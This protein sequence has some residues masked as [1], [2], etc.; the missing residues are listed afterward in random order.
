MPLAIDF[1]TCNTIIARWNEALADVEAPS[2]PGLSGRYTY[3]VPRDGE[4]QTANVIPSLIHYGEEDNLRVGAQVSDAGLVNHR[5]T[6]RWLKMDM[7]RGSRQKRRVNGRLITR[8]DAAGELLGRMLLFT[9]GHLGNADDDLVATIPVEAY[10]HYVEWLREA[11]GKHFPQGVLVVDEAT[12]C[13]LGYRD[14]VKDGEVYVVI[15]FGGGTLDV[16]VVRTNLQADADRKCVVLG[17]AGEEIGGMLVDEWMLDHLASAEE[18]DRQDVDDVRTMLLTAVEEA[19]IALSSGDPDADVTVLNDLT[20]TLISHTFSRDAFA[21]LLEDKGLYDVVDATI[22]RALEGAQLKYGTRKSE[23]RGVFMVGGGS[24][25]L[26]VH[27]LVK[28]KFRRCDVRCDNPFEAVARGACLYAG[29][30]VTQDIVHDYCLR[31]WDSEIKDY[32]L[33]PVVPKGTEY[34]TERP[35]SAKYVKAA[36]EG[37][38]RIGLVVIERSYMQLG[39]RLRELNPHDTEFIHADPPCALGER[40]FVAQ[41]AVDEHKRLII[42]LRDTRENSRSYVQL[43]NGERFDLP[44]KNFPVVRL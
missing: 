37:A 39:E 1:G 5:G 21:E 44:V 35:V 42:S 33:V 17:R 32:V 18:V 27:D 22:D 34:P 36:C 16:S 11:G 23:I 6:F 4:A 7:V 26:G 24:L 29:G 3:R 15:D 8:S 14:T 28:G 20:A 31:G 38:T 25:L 43:A 13:I 10:D 2:I 9:R 40:R 19:K 12:A 30:D 41:F